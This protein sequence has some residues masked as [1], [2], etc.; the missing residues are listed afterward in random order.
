MEFVK[1]ERKTEKK[2]KVDIAQRLLSWPDCYYRESSAAVRKELLDEA[3]R[4]GLT[5]ED[6][7]FRRK[8]Y[9]LRYDS[10]RG[11]DG[12]PIDN[13]MKAWMELRFL[14]DS[15]DRL[16]SGRNAKK[17]EKVM[18]GIGFDPGLGRN[19]LGVL[20]QEI[21]HLGLLYISLCQADK[22][23]NSLIFGFGTIS[24]DRQARKI[25]A[26][27]RRV[28][29]EIPEKYGMKEKY[30]LFTRALTEAYGEM[31]PDYAGEVG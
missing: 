6:N 9:E 11:P 8:L 20:Y 4:Q 2:E 21:R 27:F 7:V 3:D 1:R 23:Y 24:E 26:E 28:A 13:F 31:F 25:A 5:P 10:R 22:N 29:E 17:F 16:F 30:G 15:A 19:E 12:D 14:G 18:A